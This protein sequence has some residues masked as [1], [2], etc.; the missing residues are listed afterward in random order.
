MLG[1]QW[2]IGTN[3][4]LQLKLEDDNPLQDSSNMSR[5]VPALVLSSVI[6]KVITM[7]GP[8]RK[9]LVQGSLGHHT[10]RVP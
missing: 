10:P 6:K 8:P 9:G 7:N 5:W 2:I 3:L 4:E 1:G